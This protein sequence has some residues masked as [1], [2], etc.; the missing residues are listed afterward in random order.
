MMHMFCVPLYVCVYVYVYMHACIYLQVRRRM[1]TSYMYLLLTHRERF[2]CTLLKFHTGLRNY[3]AGYNLDMAVPKF[4]LFRGPQTGPQ[5]PQ[6]R[7][8]LRSESSHDVGKPQRDALFLNIRP[9]SQP[10]GFGFRVQGPRYFLIML[11]S[12]GQDPASL[13]AR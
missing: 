6:V 4:T 11:K 8:V 13:Y 3:N 7:T 1:Y 12:S 9:L 2:S 10:G 5:S